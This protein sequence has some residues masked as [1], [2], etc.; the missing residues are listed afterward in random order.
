MRFNFVIQ[1][2]PEHIR[3]LAE[4]GIASNAPP[5]LK[6]QALRLLSGFNQPPPFNRIIT[7]YVPVPETNGEEWDRLDPVRG[8]DLLVSTALEGEY[9]GIGVTPTLSR[10]SIELRSTALTVFNVKPLLFI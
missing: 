2:A 6:A 1:K 5:S 4:L 9:G 7:P 3:L 10:D 8:I